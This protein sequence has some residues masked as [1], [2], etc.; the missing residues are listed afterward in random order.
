MNTDVNL[1]LDALVV[2][3]ETAV[4]QTIV[5][6]LQCAGY[7]T[8]PVAEPSEFS[9]MEMPGVFDLA[10]VPSDISVGRGTLAGLQ[11][12]CPHMRIV[13][14][15]SPV[16]ERE[17]FSRVVGCVQSR[18]SV[19]QV[20]QLARCVAEIRAMEERLAELRAETTLTPRFP[21]IRPR[22]TR[23]RRVMDHAKQVAGSGLPLL[24][25]GEYGV[26]KSMLAGL[27]HQWGSHSDGPCVVLRGSSDDV[28]GSPAEAHGLIERVD[29]SA[30]GGTLVF[31]EIGDFSLQNQ[32][33]VLRLLAM[34]EDRTG[35][36]SSGLNGIK[37]VVTTSADLSAA[38]GKGSFRADLLSLLMDE[39]I[40][41][42]PLRERAEDVT[43]MA[44]EI[45]MHFARSYHRPDLT[46]VPEARLALLRHSWPG[47]VPE[48]RN[49][50]ERVVLTARRPQIGE[51]ELR[52]RSAHDSGCHRNGEFLSLDA[53]EKQQILRVI[54]AAP[55]LEEAARILQVDISTLWRK[56]RR[57]GI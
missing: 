7:H 55:T 41:I 29:V 15:G 31:R 13:F 10:F 12:R 9:G 44:E 21:I 5:E 8:V 17:R 32:A 40:Y 39:A 20:Q 38:A 42:P 47:N 28:P 11:Q 33:Q 16:P 57:Y 25:R 19:E 54:R 1:T 50:I 18:P 51:S 23:M 14:I 22:N 26:G 3:P 43:A 34:A 4:R 49:T 24:I 30:A 56:R 37:I 36:E 6:G 45:L 53:L 46:L 52:L 35:D 48:L 27:I 2:E